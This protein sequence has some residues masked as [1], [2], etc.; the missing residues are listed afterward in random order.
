MTV[1]DSVEGKLRGRPCCKAPG[2]SG[3]LE[4]AWRPLRRPQKI[5]HSSSYFLQKKGQRKKFFPVDVYL[6]CLLGMVK[7]RTDVAL[8]R[9]VGKASRV[10]DCELTQEPLTQ[11]CQIGI[12]RWNA[13]PGSRP[14]DIS[15]LLLFR[16]SGAHGGQ[17]ACPRSH[18][19]KR[20]RRTC[21][22]TF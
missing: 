18:G 12:S 8:N 4:S 9:M 6:R 5:K 3:S 1:R 11:E 21:G 10:T 22:L 17:V 16:F 15:E 19:S 14:L 7:I 13:R 20:K 2:L